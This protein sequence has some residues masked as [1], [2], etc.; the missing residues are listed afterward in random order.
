MRSLSARSLA[1]GWRQ[2]ENPAVSAVVLELHACFAVRVFAS[3][4]RGGSS[5]GMALAIGL[6]VTTSLAPLQDRPKRSG[7]NTTDDLSILVKLSRVL[8]EL[9][10]R[11]AGESARA[12]AT[13]AAKTLRPL[14]GPKTAIASLEREA[15]ELRARLSSRAESAVD[16]LD[17]K[18]T[19][20]LVSQIDGVACSQ[21]HLRLPT[22]LAG[23]V[24]ASA[25]ERCPHC[26]RVVI[27]TTRAS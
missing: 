9:L 23:S 17:R 1:N 20:P 2:L 26:K 24:A 3:R 15:A 27:A 14:F 6:A 21:C 10:G 19:L 13:E 7:A 12:G 4:N 5:V 18:G 8:V 25:F 11:R 16:V 22:A